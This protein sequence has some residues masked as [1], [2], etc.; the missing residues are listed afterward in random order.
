MA[1]KRRP[2][3]KWY[4][5]DWRGDARL[6][7]V[8]FAARGLWADMLSLMGGECEPFGFLFMEG[9]PLAAPDLA[10]L[11]GGSERE[12]QSLLDVLEAKN[13]FSKVGD[14]GLPGDVLELIPDGI[15]H[16][17]IFS[18]RMLRDEQKHILSQKHGKTGGNPSLKGETK[19][20]VNPRDKAQ[21]PEA[22]DQ[23]PDKKETAR[24]LG[25]FSDEAKAIVACFDRVRSDV[26]GP[27]QARPFRNATDITFAQR[28]VDLGCTEEFARAEFDRAFTAAKRDSRQPIGSLKYF[29]NA[30]PDALK[31]AN[32]APPAADLAA[33]SAEIA[34]PGITDC[35]FP[36]GR[37]QMW[38]Y[39][40]T[41]YFQGMRW[42]SMDGE[43]PDSTNKLMIDV[44]PEVL[45]LFEG[46]ERKPA[47][48]VAG[49]L[50]RT[51]P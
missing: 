37:L 21:R 42:L 32:A 12:V 19:G 26:F 45:K 46:R 41:K 1:E 35:P 24:G 23:R 11:L 8:S 16:G 17:T 31:A 6:R 29:Q 36:D 49:L 33:N 34:V 38:F 7:R 44:P 15:K 27:E 10:K 14:S 4:W 20:G 9:E 39:K 30:I 22:R 2:W 50:E 40:C 25:E 18:R 43:P 47:G 5:T 3:G 13:V 51:S 28:W 48:S